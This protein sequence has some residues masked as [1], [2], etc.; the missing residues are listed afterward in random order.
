MY[1][2]PDFFLTIASSYLITDFFLAVVSLCCTIL[3]FFSDKFLS[4][5]YI[6]SS[7]LCVYI[8]Q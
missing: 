7:Q 8:S 6:F 4:C 3:T 1:S 2:N 5:N